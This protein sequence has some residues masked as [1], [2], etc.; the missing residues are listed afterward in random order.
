MVRLPRD[1]PVAAGQGPA[2]VHR[3]VR[4]CRSTWSVEPDT[5]RGVG[6]S[7]QGLHRGGP[8][9]RLVALLLYW[10]TLRH[11]KGAQLAARVI[12][13]WKHLDLA[14]RAGQR[15]R[16]RLG[17]IGI[18]PWRECALDEVGRFTFLNETRSLPGE[19]GWN[20]PRVPKLW[21]YNLH[22]FD[23]IN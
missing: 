8:L 2:G 5:V 20:E 10:H 15:L 6:G 22:Y 1:E 9:S 23:W 14:L 21:L 11:L 7:I 3:S 19:G 12:R 18:D 4:E 17:P 16:A 13:N